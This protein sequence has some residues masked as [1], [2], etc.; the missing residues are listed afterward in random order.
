MRDGFGSS[1]TI[2]AGDGKSV[3]KLTAYFYPVLSLHKNYSAEHLPD[4]LWKVKILGTTVE[5]KKE[6][7]TIRLIFVNFNIESPG[8]TLCAC[9]KLLTPLQIPSAHQRRALLL[10]Q[11]QFCGH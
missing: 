3:L 10:A 9:F 5:I 7:W 6:T 1:L 11:E 4:K 2:R 8:R